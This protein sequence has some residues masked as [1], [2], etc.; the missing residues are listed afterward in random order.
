MGNHNEFGKLGEEKATA[1][2]QRK[3]YVIHERNYRYLKAEID[4]I[5]QKGDILAVVEVKSRSTGFL[6]TLS[7]SVNLKK[8]KLLV[9]AA[10]YYVREQNLDV[11]VRFDVITLLQKGNQL[12]LQHIQ[13][14]FY[15]F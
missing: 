14:A 3:G 5:A 10:D 11:E 13:D 7:D 12:E 6:E 15:P 2:L 1:L 9:M 8:R 4:I